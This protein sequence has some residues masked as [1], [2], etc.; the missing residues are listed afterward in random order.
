[1]KKIF[2]ALFVFIHING[3]AQLVDPITFSE[4]THDFG[5]VKEANGSVAFDFTVTNKSTRAIKILK[6]QPSCGCT[7]PDWTKEAI[8]AGGT[9]FVRASFDPKGRPGY[10]NKSLTVT[11]DWDGN[12]VVLQIKGNVV[13]EVSEKDPS[14][15]TVER[16][17]LKF[18]SNSFNLEK[19]FIN[20]EPEPI[21]V[22]CYNPT[23]DTIHFQ[24]FVGPRYIRMM[25]PKFVAPHSVATLKILFD[26]QAKGQYGFVI[27]SIDINTDDRHM[28]QKTFSVYATVEEYFPKLSNEE[29]AN[30]PALS[31][32][33]NMVRFG[34]V[35]AGVI[36]EREVKLI[37]TGKKE[38]IIRHA[39]SNCS[40]LEVTPGLRV[41]KP[42]Q[43]TSIKI[44][45]KTEGRVGP[46][47]K[48]VT[49]YSTDPKNPVQRITFSAGV[50]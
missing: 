38:L 15:F 34:N 14:T 4:K 28:L 19:V 16:G 5:I 46:Q 42:G 24:G 44:K 30:A 8:A 17:S 3:Q 47:N 20:R 33:A 37:N 18:K 21:S 45:L 32:S 1:M 39:Q 48:S 22:M 23:Q 27:E 31:L 6:V 43:E 13:N 2:F 26:A 41:L 9:G 49:I 36:L 35:K 11:T 12:P 10:F 25:L 29:L 40:C 50:I 7:T